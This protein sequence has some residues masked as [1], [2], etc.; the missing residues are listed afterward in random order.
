MNSRH[1]LHTHLPKIGIRPI[2]DGRYG[3]VRESL[4]ES[5]LKMA[6]RAAHLIETELKHTCGSN[7]E[8]VV[9]GFCIGGIQ[10]SAR[11]EKLFQAEHVGVSLSVTPCWC[12]G[13]E[14]MD[15]DSI[16]PKAIWGF[17]GTERPGAV[18]LAAT[19]AAHA[20]KGLPC[21]GIYGSE[22][23]DSNDDE[24]P[25]DVRKKLL[26]FARCG[27]AVAKMRSTTYCAMGGMSMG[28][29]GSMV[30]Q[31]FFEK[32]LG[33][34]VESIDMSEFQRRISLEIFDK[35]EFSKAKKWVHAFCKEGTDWNSEKHKRS[36]KS[37][38]DS[39]DV[40]IKM[41]LIARDLMIG[42]PKLAE[43]GFIEE[44]LGRNAI[45]GGFQGQRQW[46][47]FMP[48]GDFMEA[49]LTSS[50]DWNGAR[51]PFAF[52]TENDSLNA[53]CMLFGQLLTGKAQLFSDVRTYWS[54]ES[55]KR[56]TGHDLAGNAKNGIIH[57]IN[58][59][60]SALDWTG[61]SRTD[62][63][64]PCLKEFWNLAESDVLACLENTLWCPSMTEYFPG[65]GWSTDFTTLGEM[66]VTMSRLNLVDG[67]GPVLQIVE[68]WTVDLPKEVHKQL[69]ERTNPTWP[70]TWF[71]PRLE[72]AG[73]FESVYSVMSAWGANHGAISHGH[74]GSELVTLA[75]MLRIPV[76]MH[77]TGS[78]FRPAVWSR[79]GANDPT[80]SD[81]RA[82]QN[83]GPLYG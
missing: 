28:I 5:V 39:W 81:Y 44:S 34:A 45:A 40:S 47:D 27:L 79:F 68:G 83:F 21:F 53:A 38:D 76:D 72:S 61:Q 22:V 62:E 23:Q 42:N 37:L 77:N 19:L 58:S 7:V 9:P 54:R 35:E 20:Q 25:S 66:P 64:K 24:I 56:V 4:E 78:E 8:C 80:G 16:R 11:V 82:C 65:G 48:N 33:M 1:R 55:V 30:D 12:Y 36:R 18:Y 60:P 43:M 32:Y 10:E 13:A 49:M 41:A 51:E 57:L 69:D 67:L 3:G 73:V 71:A 59:G 31:S 50:F 6:K 46:T 52:A 26:T 17:N 2:I 14:T 29:V 75:S 63:G 15:R 74:I 70:T